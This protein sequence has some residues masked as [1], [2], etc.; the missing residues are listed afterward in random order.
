MT[1]MPEELF[2]PGDRIRLSEA[3]R[4]QFRTA[5]SRGRD[6]GTFVRYG[7]SHYHVSFIYVRFDNQSPNALPRTYSASFWEKV[8]DETPARP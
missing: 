3:G 8:E 4:K 5:K 1:F 2:Q 6:V 7:T